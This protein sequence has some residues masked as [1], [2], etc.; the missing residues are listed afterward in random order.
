MALLYLMRVDLAIWLMHSFSNYV[1]VCVRVCVCA[2]VSVCVC[3]CVHVC[4]CVYVCACMYVC[5]CVRVCVCVCVCVCVHMY[6]ILLPVGLARHHRLGV[7]HLLE[8]KMGV[9][10]THT[11]IHMHTR[12]HAYTHKHTQRMCLDRACEAVDFSL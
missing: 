12:T 9:W 1:Y 11:H 4:A 6:L 5:V 7:E 3:V 2:C 8:H 10:K